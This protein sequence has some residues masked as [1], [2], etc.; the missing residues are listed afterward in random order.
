MESFSN[1]TYFLSRVPSNRLFRVELLVHGN[2]IESNGTW[3]IAR[4]LKKFPNLE[5]F[6]FDGY[7]NHIKTQGVKPITILLQKLTKLRHLSLD[8]DL[9]YIENEGGRL[10]GSSIH[11]LNNL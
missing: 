10:L 11:F 8:F 4:A 9:N 5:V 7:F 2:R 3:D 6:K 1:F